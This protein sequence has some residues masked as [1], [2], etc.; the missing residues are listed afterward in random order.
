MDHSRP[1]AMPL[2][3]KDLSTSGGTSR[4]E[5][6]TRELISMVE[7]KL[8]DGDRTFG[9]NVV[10]IDLSTE[11]GIPGMS[12]KDQ[13][14]FVYSKLISHLKDSGFEVCIELNQTGTTLHVAFTINFNDEQVKAMYGVIKKHIAADD[15]AVRKFVRGSEVADGPAAGAKN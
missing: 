14:L 1:A 3:A 15:E 10:S 7:A 9:R 8:R 6:V 13:Q 2:T 5:T 11:F 12:M 4:L